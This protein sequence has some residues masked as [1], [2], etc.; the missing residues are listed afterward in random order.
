[1]N[2]R[3]DQMRTDT[4]VVAMLGFLGFM[5]LSLTELT[6]WCPI[7]L[8]PVGVIMLRNSV[9]ELVYV[10]VTDMYWKD[11]E[12]LYRQQYWEEMEAMFWE[13][14][15][16]QQDYGYVEGGRHRLNDDYVNAEYYNH[17]YYQ[18]NSHYAYA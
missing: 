17:G 13:N 15:D 9:V 18:H 14:I 2:E 11:M 16:Y 5:W 12:E 1:M 8:F 7:I 6:Q 10:K 4:F 3:I